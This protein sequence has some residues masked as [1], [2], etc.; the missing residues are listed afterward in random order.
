MAKRAPALRIDG[1][2]GALALVDG[3]RP[4]PFLAPGLPQRWHEGRV[5]GRD[6]AFGEGFHV[7]Y[8]RRGALALLY[9]DSGSNF[10]GRWR[11]SLSGKPF[12]DIYKSITD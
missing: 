11:H 4:A 5:E 2:A 9:A 10:L 8:I 3:A 6:F 7:R 12:F 1:K